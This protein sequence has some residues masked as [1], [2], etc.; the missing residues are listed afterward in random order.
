MAIINHTHRFIFVHVPKAAGT[1]VTQHLSQYTQYCDLEIGG[2]EFGEMI[3]PAYS[4]RF[5]ISKHSTASKLRG[6]MGSIEWQKYFSFAFVRNPFLRTYS[7]YQFLRKWDGYDTTLRQRIMEFDSF[8][9]FVMSD[10]FL[11]PGPDQI[12]NPQVFWLWRMP[13][14]R[15]IGVSYVGKLETID[16]DMAVI[17]QVINDRVTS[18]SVADNLALARREQSDR[19]VKSSHANKSSPV[20]RDAFDDPKVVSR[21]RERYKQDFERFDYSL[22][23]PETS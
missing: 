4:R 7:I 10:I 15:Q 3:Q 17:D 14:E 2:T 22:A 20:T 11:T 8:Q 9:D 23:P 21:I 13:G 12:L 1:S 18:M 16:E 5:G 19:R 6:I